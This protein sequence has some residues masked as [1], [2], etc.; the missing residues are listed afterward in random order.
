MPAILSVLF[1]KAGIVGMIAVGLLL[2]F[3]VQEARLHHAK[4]DLTAL[5]K[6]DAAA[7]ALAV[8][9]QKA[10]DAISA[11]AK[12][13]TASQRAQIVTQTKTLIQKVRV[14]V[15]AA[16]DA[17]CV[18]PAG[19]VQLH[20]LAASGLSS[21]ASGSVEAASG[22]QLSTVLETVI[23]NYGVAYDWRAEALGWRSWY[24]AQ[25]AAWGK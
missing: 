5:R 21:P 9:R 14:Y 10:S 11:S 18:I 4:A 13:E 25:A 1:S 16:A 19:F 7:Q 12:T 6:A 24:K 22:V 8:E 23:G 2:L 15:P 20:D 3:G 17:Q